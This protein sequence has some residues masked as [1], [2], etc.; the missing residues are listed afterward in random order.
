MTQ[1]KDTMLLS[2]SHRSLPAKTDL[3]R[4]PVAFWI[5]QRVRQMRK[6]RELSLQELATKLSMQKSYLS[7]IENGG[8]EISLK[9]LVRIFHD[10]F[11]K[12]LS[13]KI[14]DLPRKKI[15]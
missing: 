2:W 1:E 13:L 7:R 9:E 4:S 12:S 6:E 14:D 5:G 11:G 10:G 8:V 15:A 3:R